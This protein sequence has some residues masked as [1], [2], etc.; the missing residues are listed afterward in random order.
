MNHA[1]TKI[2]AAGFVVELDGADL[3]IEP[4][5]KLTLPQV[6]FLKSH[7][8]DIIQALQREQAANDT[9][10]PALVPV[11]DDRH[12]CH[13]CQNLINRHCIAQWFRPHDDI[14]RRCSDFTL[15]SNISRQGTGNDDQ[16]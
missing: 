8:A 16:S 11:D 4:F 3:A 12:H 6:Q 7:K 15:L 13:E 14:P 5:S 9:P 1:L 10:T 2:K